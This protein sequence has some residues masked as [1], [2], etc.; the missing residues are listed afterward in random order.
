MKI[1]LIKSPPP[2]HSSIEIV[3]LSRLLFALFLHAG[4]TGALWSSRST[5]SIK[6]QNKEKRIVVLSKSNFVEGKSLKFWWSLN[7]PRGH[8]WSYTKFGPDRFSRFDICWIQTYTKVYIQDE[9]LPPK[10][11]CSNPYIFA[12]LQIFDRTELIVWNN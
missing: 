10:F 8:A 12:T 5:Y 4:L 9:S 7:L 3:M 2:P 11:K 6:I 1:E